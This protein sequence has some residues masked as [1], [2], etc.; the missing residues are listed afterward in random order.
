MNDEW[1][2]WGEWV[3]CSSC[4]QGFMPKYEWQKK[5]WTCFLASA[6]GRAWQARKEQQSNGFGRNSQEQYERAR[7][8]EQQQQQQE[9]GYHGRFTS[10]VL[11]KDFLRKLIMLCHPD[12]HGGSAMSNEVTKQLLQ[13]KEKL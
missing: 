3:K 5:C 8:G 2:D 12:K 9:R 6:E 11:D 13:M 10:P 1:G 4:R 7:R